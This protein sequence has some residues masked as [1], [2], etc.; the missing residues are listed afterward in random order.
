MVRFI[1]NTFILNLISSS[2]I[3]KVISYDINLKKVGNI[4][5]GFCPFH[6]EKNPSFTVNKTENFYYCFG[7][8]VHGNIIDFLMNY[9]KLTFIESIK[10]L[11]YLNCKKIIYKKNYNYNFYLFKKKK[12]I[13]YKFMNNMNKVYFFSLFNKKKKLILDYLL[14]RGLNLKSIKKFS[15]GFSCSFFFNRFI[16]YYKKKELDFLV[17]IGILGKNKYNFIFDKLNNRIIFPIFDIKKR[18]V[19]FGG[20]SINNLYNFKYIN[21][22]NNIFFS[23]KCCLYGLCYIKKDN[24]KLNRIIVVEGYIDVIILNQFKIKYVVGLLGSS[25]SNE[26]I[27]IL[28]NY[29]DNI[30]F[31]YDGDES[32]L[33]SLKRTINILFPYVSEGKNFYFMFLPK[34]EDPDSIIRKKGKKFF[35]KIIKS[36]ISFFDYFFKIMSIGINVN[37]YENKIKFANNLLP[38]I[39]KIESPLIRIF[40]RKKLSRIIGLFDE[41]ILEKTINLNINKKKIIKKKF[42]ILRYLIFFLIKKPYLSRLVNLYD[43]LFS[44]KKIIYGLCLFLNIVKICMYEKNISTND[45]INSC[46]NYKVKYYLNILRLCKF[47]DFYN[48]NVNINIV[49][50]DFL[51]KL[52]IIIINRKLDIMIKKEQIMGLSKKEKIIFWNLIKL[53]NLKK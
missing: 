1:S 17:N 13:F 4:Y 19:A 37:T 47:C 5:K 42:L 18:V 25:I 50:V 20:R 31:C 11:S 46:V 44:E 24:Y 15:I 52:K 39:Y 53:K 51:N 7:C 27:K 21:S 30:I 23:K 26:Q 9:H 28:F 32:G 35:E 43:P 12:Y 16:K 33:I 8:K 6:N 10:E 41:R 38:Y 3:V 34:G 48:E 45:I 29:T 2:D 36:S 49:F 14:K 22:S 40:L